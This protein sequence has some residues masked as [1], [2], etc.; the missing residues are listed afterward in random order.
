VAKACI[1]NGAAIIN[2]IS[3][4]NLDDAMF[5]VT[6]NKVPYMICHAWHT[7]NDAEYDPV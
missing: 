3:A 2:D 1:E 6:S 5:E 4:G 7:T